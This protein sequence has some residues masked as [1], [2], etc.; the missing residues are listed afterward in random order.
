[1]NPD[2]LFQIVNTLVLPMWL[3]LIFAPKWK[4]TKKLI[5][6]P[7]IPVLLAIC[8]MVFGGMAMEGGQTPD[9]STLEGVKTALTSDL[10]FLAGW[11]H[12]LTF[13]LAIGMWLVVQNRSLGLSKWVMAP[14]LVFTFMLGP[15]GFLLFHLINLFKKA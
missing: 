3:L 7:A 10:A 1:M 4:V 11:V 9:F 13:D 6:F 12:Y 2:T 5:S 14:V 15:V 8:Y